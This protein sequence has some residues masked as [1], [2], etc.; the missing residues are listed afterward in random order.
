TLAVIGR[1]GGSLHVRGRTP[2]A[3]FAGRIAGSGN[4]V[5]G[6]RFACPAFADQLTAHPDQL[7]DLPA[8]LAPEDA[9]TVLYYRFAL[10]AFERLAAARPRSPVIICGGTLAC[11]LLERRLADD[12]VASRVI[13]SPEAISDEVRQLL[14]AD[15]P[16]VVGEGRFRPPLKRWIG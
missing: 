7:G 8:D 13:P 1:A 12:Q 3:S 16:L 9:A 6:Y 4:R 10:S 11:R 5:A 15:A 14:D 2:V